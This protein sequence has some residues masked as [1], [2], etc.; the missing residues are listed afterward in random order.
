MVSMQLIHRYHLSG[1]CIYVSEKKFP[2]VCPG[3]V[4]LSWY[5]ILVMYSILVLYCMLVLVQYACPSTV[6]LSCYSILVLYC[7]FVL[8]QYTC[9]VL[10][11]CPGTY[12]CPVLYACPGTVCLSWYDM[13]VLVQYVCPG[14]VCLSWYSLLVLVQYACP[15]TFA[16]HDTLCSFLNNMLLLVLYPESD[17]EDEEKSD[18]SVVGQDAPQETHDDLHPANT[19]PSPDKVDSCDDWSPDAEIEPMSDDQKME[20]DRPMNGPVLP[21][22]D[23][24]SAE[25][26]TDGPVPDRRQKLDSLSQTLDSLS[27]TLEEKSKWKKDICKPVIKAE[28]PHSPSSN[29]QPENESRDISS[30]QHATPSGSHGVSCLFRRRRRSRSRSRSKSGG[31]SASP[32][33]PPIM[34][35]S[36]EEA[37]RALVNQL[38]LPSDVLY[39]RQQEMNIHGTPSI[40]WVVCCAIPLPQG[41]SLGPFQGQLVPPEAVKVG[42][43]IVQ[44][45]N[46]KGQQALMNVAGQSG[47]WLALLRSAGNG[48]DRNT[49]VYWEGG[50]IWCE[51]IA[52]ID[53]GTELRAS[54]SFQSDEDGE[55]M[56]LEDDSLAVG[57]KEEHN[58]AD[59]SSSSNLS[60]TSLQQ[61]PHQQSAAPGHAALIYGCPFCGVRFSSPRTLQGHLSFYCSKKTSDLTVTPTSKG[62]D[63]KGNPG[64]TTSVEVKTEQDFSHEPAVRDEVEFAKDLTQRSSEI[65]EQTFRCKYCSYKADKLSSLNRHMRMHN[66]EKIK[67][68]NINARHDEKDEGM[69]HERR[70]RVLKSPVLE[71]FCKECRIQFSSLHTYRCHKEHYCAQR[72]KKSLTNPSAFAA[73]FHSP[74]SFADAANKVGIPSALQMAALNQGGLILPG[75]PGEANI[76]GGT[77]V[78]L[79]APM[80]TT[81]GMAKITLSVPAMIVKSIVPGQESLTPLTSPRLASTPEP[82]EMLPSTSHSSPRPQLVHFLSPPPKND[83]KDAMEDLRKSNDSLRADVRDEDRPLDLSVT[84]IKKEPDTDNTKSKEIISFLQPDRD[85]VLDARGTIH[86]LYQSSSSPESK[87][88]ELKEDSR[89]SNSKTHTLLSS[90]DEPIDIRIDSLATTPQHFL[91]SEHLSPGA[92]QL[93]PHSS[94]LV[95]AAGFIPLPGLATLAISPPSKHTVSAPS[96]TSTS[97]SKC[98]DCNIVFYKYDNYLIHKKHYCSGKR[99][100]SL[101][102]SSDT[103]SLPSV[104]DLPHQKEQNP[105]PSPS[106]I[107]EPKESTIS[108]STANAKV[109]EIPSA[110]SP[111][112]HSSEVKYKFYCVPCRIKFSNANILEAHKEYYC[113]AGK[114]SEQSVILQS[115]SSNDSTSV[116][117]PKDEYLASP[118]PPL[119]EFSC[120]RCNSIFSSARLLRLHVC[121]GGFPCPHC[122]HISITDNRLAEHMK[123]HAPTKAYRCTICGYRGNTAR[124]MRMHGKTHIDEGL[125]FTDENMLEY[126]EPALVPVVHS[127]H[128]GS[129]TDSELLR[130][131]NEPYKRRRSRK[132]YEKFDYPLPK[133]DVPQTCLLC[134]QNFPNAEYLTSH[135]KVH[136]IAAS[137][138]I[139][140]LMKCLHCDYIGKDPDD[141]KSHFELKHLIRQ[142]KRRRMSS[143]STEEDLSTD[144]RHQYE[145]ERKKTHKHM[146]ITDPNSS[147]DEKSSETFDIKS[148]IVQMSTDT[149]TVKNEPMDEDET[150]NGETAYGETV[151]NETA[152]SETANDETANGELDV[153]SDD[154]TKIIKSG[155]LTD[156]VL[157][158]K[159]IKQ[160]D[161]YQLQVDDSDEMEPGEL[162]SRVKKEMSVE[163]ETY[164]TSGTAGS[165]TSSEND[166]HSSRRP[167]VQ[168]KNDS[169]LS[170]LSPKSESNSNFGNKTRHDSRPGDQKSKHKPEPSND[171]S[172]KSERTSPKLMAPNFLLNFS[173]GDTPVSTAHTKSSPLHLATFE[174]T[175]STVEA[176]TSYHP[177][178]LTF[179]YAAP[180]VALPYVFLQPHISPSPLPLCLKPTVR[181][182]RPGGIRYCEN[183]DI[184]FSKHS[185]YLAH[186]KYYCTSRPRGDPQPSAQA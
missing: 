63:K 76:P 7:M 145:S 16:A 39:L 22:D 96:N 90:R 102:H 130:L 133:I 1:L 49:H 105:K 47:G 61:H 103:S 82:Q 18:Q 52:D 165:H 92:S 161:T 6:C 73:M 12:T 134:G 86:T 113:P 177:H 170:S 178:H 126:H 186:K 98:L 110:L 136:E 66:S 138:Y 24:L 20:A 171:S 23:E 143:Q 97:I 77:A 116:T 55:D 131:K 74:F 185:T 54:F 183:C 48:A 59:D 172:V 25:G 50:R 160:E 64:K 127:P 9:H 29:D 70:D 150:A 4:C 184:S 40:G 30:S 69:K 91:R 99:R 179:P 176:V 155:R 144:S 56:Q 175:P 17:D 111:S 19:I 3:T 79:T 37:E 43:L 157:N 152:N 106:E 87:Y 109:K 60:C 13:F 42:D 128:P 80:L 122:D 180:H 108:Q 81:N 162:V 57:I 93:L 114:D 71:T 147:D 88:K 65:Q 38:Q 78:I 174:P 83:Y 89:S 2:T 123:I 11:A 142:S 36:R 14:A 41:S 173:S 44:F 121:D 137:Q 67:A 72:R 163:K 28:P 140:G 32:D 8:L 21:S 5:S 125:D 139:A 166:F 158:T 33:A 164:F 149:P 31:V 53:I 62:A 169:C 75:A 45:T 129:T 132:A 10:Y 58:T 120:T 94:L 84:K 104:T 181:E 85:G 117:S 100:S 118:D 34:A 46:K 156:V 101:L 159:H 151:N 119:E 15:S 35:Q 148:G 51:I 154:E 27:Q 182:E 124:G 26:Q 141:L 135:F 168:E 112:K 153:D 146:I 95:S 115:S 167:V 68:A 107:P